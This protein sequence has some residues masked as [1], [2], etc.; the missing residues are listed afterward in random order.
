MAYPL[1]NMVRGNNLAEAWAKCQKSAITD[2]KR[3]TRLFHA[4]VG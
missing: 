4:D 3:S 2:K 1:V